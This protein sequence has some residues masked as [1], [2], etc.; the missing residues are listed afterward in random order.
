MARGSLPRSER[1]TLQILVRDEIALTLE[2]GG[3]RP[4]DAARRVCGQHPDL[5]G[6]LGRLLVEE[7]VT[8]MARKEFK[9]WNAVGAASQ[10]QLVFPALAEHLRKDLPASIS[11]PP[12]ED[13]HAP[14][15]IY[16]PLT[17]PNSA[18]VGELRRALGALW[19]G[20]AND[21]RKTKALG[22]LLD[23]ALAA[24]ADD[25][26]RVAYALSR[27]ATEDALA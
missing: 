15:P 3:G 26:A 17:G 6:R 21:R 13:D 27:L 12:A 25:D 11:V 19:Q 20:I 10:E 16:R 24:G 4:R 9:K 7:A 5:V 2:S 18:T 14:E 8:A 23:L 22:D 1:A